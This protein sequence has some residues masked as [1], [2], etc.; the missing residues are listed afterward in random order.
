MLQWAPGAWGSI[1]PIPPPRYLLRGGN[2]VQIQVVLLLLRTTMLAIAIP[3][4][5][6]VL[7]SSLTATRTTETALRGT[8]GNHW[9]EGNNT[10]DGNNDKEKKLFFWEM[11]NSE[12][13]Q[14]QS[15]SLITPML[16]EEVMASAR[17]TMD[18][19]TISRA[20]SSLLINPIIDDTNNNSSNSATNDLSNNIETI[21]QG[22]K[23]NL[24]DL[25]LGSSNNN[26]NNDNGAILSKRRTKFNKNDN[27][28][29]DTQQIAIAS[30]VTTLLLSPIIIPIIHSLLPPILPFPSSIG[31]N[32]AALLGTLAYIVA[33][34][35]PTEQTN[36]GEG[37]EVGGAVSRVVGRTALQSAKASAPRLQAAARAM[38]EYDTTIST[39]DELT[40]I[41]NQLTQTVN[42]LS[43]E[44]E[45]LKVDL[46]LWRAVEDISN[47][48]KLEELKELARYH[49]LKG[50][51]GDGKNA[52]LRRL[53][54]EGIV[55]L[56]ITPYY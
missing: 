28:M 48:Y 31:F 19:N 10:D 24:R 14:Q 36:Y 42:E 4:G 56:D 55:T 5:R 45:V 49:G 23:N 46:A 15:T 43:K 8:P 20:L 27:S 29:T 3:S 34:G 25:A 38:V 44:N 17:S 33:L 26:R 51:S 16:E 6:V 53:A 52:L 50:Y 47:M 2:I 32:T 40:Q 12:Q 1:E 11:T 21:Q 39:I 18:S 13:Q 35:D 37:V 7:S 9:W 30:G 41:K 22:R 54:K